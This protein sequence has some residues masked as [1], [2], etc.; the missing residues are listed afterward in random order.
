L[1]RK[2]EEGLIHEELALRALEEVR[3]LAEGLKRGK[4][5]PSPSP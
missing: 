1:R 5:D 4:T 3:S 2:V